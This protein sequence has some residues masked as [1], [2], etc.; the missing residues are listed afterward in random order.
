MLLGIS[1]DSVASHL[2]FAVDQAFPF[3]LLAD[4]DNSVRRA[5]GALQL[6]GMLAGRVTYVI[7][8]SGRIAGY[9]NSSID[10]KLHAKR[11]LEILKQ[12]PV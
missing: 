5:Y 10:M 9:C 3:N 12:L 7:D 2:A 1:G 4:V 11:A 8:D 6:A